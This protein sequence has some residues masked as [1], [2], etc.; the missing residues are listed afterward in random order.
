MLDTFPGF[1]GQLHRNR[2]S[3]ASGFHVCLEKAVQPESERSFSF[4]LGK[5]ECVSPV[6]IRGDLMDPISFGDSRGLTFAIIARRLTMASWI[7]ILRMTNEESA[8]GN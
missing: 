1:A 6:G 5:G 4:G 3:G 2:Q 8:I 7:I